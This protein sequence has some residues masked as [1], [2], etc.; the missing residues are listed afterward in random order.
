[1]SGRNGGV[2]QSGTLS[3]SE[4]DTFLGIGASYQLSDQ[5]EL[6]M[7]DNYYKFDFPDYSSFNN[8]NAA[9]LLSL[10]WEL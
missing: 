8:K 10:K 2:N 7:E 3:F 4:S 1:M 9:V 5:L 6:E